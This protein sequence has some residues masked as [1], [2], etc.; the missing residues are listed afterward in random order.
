RRLHF[1]ALDT[2]PT[3]TNNGLRIPET[4]PDV[5]WTIKASAQ[6]F[7]R[8][9]D[10]TSGKWSEAVGAYINR[11]PNRSIG[12]QATPEGITV[13]W[14]YDKDRKGYMESF[15][16]PFDRGSKTKLTGIPDVLDLAPKDA[17]PMFGGIASLPLATNEVLLQGT[18]DGLYITC[19]TDLAHHRCFLP[20]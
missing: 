9:A 6:D 5:A 20:A 1:H 17:M 13:H 12:V 14:W 8:F 18:K 4:M 15:D 19:E 3:E 7:K 11:S 16:V 10:R 2:V